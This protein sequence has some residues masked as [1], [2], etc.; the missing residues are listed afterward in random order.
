[1]A[2]WQNIG[3]ITMDLECYKYHLIEYKGG[4]KYVYLLM[5]QGN[6]EPS[7]RGVCAQNLQTRGFKNDDDVT[8]VLIF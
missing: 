1:M 3:K 7:H 5:V 6:R 8:L 4:I 2:K